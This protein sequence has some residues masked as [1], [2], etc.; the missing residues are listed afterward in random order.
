MVHTEFLCTI[1]RQSWHH[2]LRFGG[3]LGRNRERVQWAL[4]C[5]KGITITCP[6]DSRKRQ[7]GYAINIT[8]RKYWDLAQDAASF[9]E[10]DYIYRPNKSISRVKLVY[11]GST[12]RIDLDRPTAASYTVKHMSSWPSIRPWIKWME[13]GARGQVNTTRCVLLINP[14]CTSHSQYL[15]PWA[16]ICQIYGNQIRAR[17]VPLNKRTWR[18][19]YWTGALLAIWMLQF[20]RQTISINKLIHGFEIARIW[21]KKDK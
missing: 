6:W 2:V 20:I 14:R 3:H 7:V 13:Y 19:G 17:S 21:V 12:R 9:Y 11:H 15:S 8:R 16:W 1:T 4:S 5:F 10:Q 18:C